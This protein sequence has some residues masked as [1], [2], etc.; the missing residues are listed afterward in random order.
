MKINDM[1][2]DQIREFYA[3]IG[4]RMNVYFIMNLSE[5]GKLIEQSI[6]K[7]LTD[8][9]EIDYDL[10]PMCLGPLIAIPFEPGHTDWS[11]VSQIMTAVHELAHREHMKKGSI[12]AWY[13][14]YFGKPE[15]RSIQEVLSRYAEAQVL[16][17]YSKFIPR[18]DIDS[19]YFLDGEEVARA[20]DTYRFLVDG[21]KRNPRGT[22]F[23][24]SARIC[25]DILEDL[26][27]KRL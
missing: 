13:Q 1:T 19:G 2:S 25:I 22:T 15:F 9:P 18:L 3:E 8:L 16:Y 21:I 12:W 5:K 23:N 11:P 7:V 20:E 14:N 6:R 24:D 17:W 27:V 26:G 4:K 10:R